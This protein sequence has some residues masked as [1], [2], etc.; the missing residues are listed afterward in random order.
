MMG[1][2]DWKPIG[3]G[4]LGAYLTGLLF[5]LVILPC[6]TPVLASILAYAAQQQRTLSGAALLF[7][8]GAGIGA[9]LSLI[10]ASFGLIS[11]VRPGFRTRMWRK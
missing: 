5:A 3:A 10:G 7:T 11:S 4:M 8:Y 1:L 2:Q 6:A 9:P